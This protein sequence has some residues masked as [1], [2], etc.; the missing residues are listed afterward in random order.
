MKGSLI[1]TFRLQEVKETT[2]ISPE[3]RTLASHIAGGHKTTVKESVCVPAGYPQGDQ[4][5]SRHVAFQRRIV[6]AY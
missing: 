3:K 1:S 6:P 2:A 5:C 4:A